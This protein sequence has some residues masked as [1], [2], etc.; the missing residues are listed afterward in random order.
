MYGVFGRRVQS[1]AASAL[2]SAQFIK[3]KN[4]SGKITIGAA[5][6]GYE[7]SVVMGMPHSLM[8]NWTPVLELG[9]GA[10]EVYQKIIGLQ[11]RQ[12]DR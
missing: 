6:P 11:Q 9:N 7:L 12:A 5:H 2:S 8:G 4:G 3:Q 10:E 1:V